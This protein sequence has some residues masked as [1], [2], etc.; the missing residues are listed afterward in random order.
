[1]KLATASSPLLNAN[2]V[3]F[4]DRAVAGIIRRLTFRNEQNGYFV[5]RIAI[6]G[7][8]EEHTVVGYAS[9]INEGERL[10]AEGRWENSKYGRQFKATSVRLSAP[11]D[12]E[13]LQKFLAGALKGIGPICAAK[14][15]AAFGTKVADVLTNQPERLREV[16][17]IGKKRARAIIEAWQSRG[18][19]AEVLTWL[20]GLGLSLRF[21]QRILQEY[22]DK[23]RR[24]VSHN[25]YELAFS[26][27]GIGF[28]K[29]DAIARRL[30]LTES[31]P[32]RVRAALQHLMQE[33]TE[34]GS[35]GLPQQ[36]LIEQAHTLLGFAPSAARTELIRSALAQ[37][38]EERKLI[39]D[40]VHGEDCVFL[41][42]IYEAEKAIARDLIA[43]LM[44]PVRPIEGLE[45][46][47]QEAE[48]DLGVTLE[49]TQREAVLRALR[50]RVFV[51]TGGP[52]TGKTTITRAIVR[53]LEK[54]GH[55]VIVCA[56]TGKAAKRASEAIG[57]EARTIHRTLE[58]GQ[59]GPTRDAGSPLDCDALVC[60]ELSMVDVPLFRALLEALPKNAR[61]ILVGDAD[62]LPSV[63][64][65]KVLTDLLGSG[66]I[67]SV[68]LIEVFRQAQESLIIQNAH[69]VNSGKEPMLGWQADTDFGFFEF[70]DAAATRDALLRTA[71]NIWKR[72]FDPIRD[73]QVLA[74]MRN[75]ELGVDRLNVE[76]QKMLNPMPPASMPFHNGGVLGVGDKV[77]QL[78]NNYTKEVFNGEIGF[79]QAL[80]PENRKVTVEF[81]G[82]LVEYTA[83]DLDEI[84][85]AYAFT[86]HRS[87]GSEFPVVLMVLANQHY[88]ML[89]RNLLY[90]GIT[91]ARKL[92]FI[93]GSRWAA[94]QAARN[95]QI[96]ERYSKLRDW[97]ADARTNSMAA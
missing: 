84:R 38:I 91:R 17:G 24:I 57:V 16:P 74:P 49:S 62:Q 34:F 45:E 65:G 48:I 3:N 54:S 71:Q 12:E 52:G 41:P 21:A 47:I 58:W 19:N 37:L 51:L 56:P 69:R 5:A 86:I 63:G 64:P 94:R 77:I 27:H 29:A 67:P 79:V 82:R 83:D 87:Q 61:L 95:C 6:P 28:R 92:M 50:E 59:T 22:G 55:D 2:E 23:T 90:T 39:A 88:V 85:L 46:A 73:V 20:C 96:E 81:D 75:G 14:L 80:D 76:L 7:I 1:M 35:C 18:E 11:A 30:G 9:Q 42:R 13:G 70:E 10:E 40:T 68:R 89:K 78:R 44:R 53:V 93:F 43:R 25:P 15:V 36:R 31:N 32:H 66:V 97:L 60:D 4:A 33:A 26:I 8:K 72:G